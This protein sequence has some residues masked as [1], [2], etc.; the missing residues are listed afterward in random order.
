MNVYVPAAVGIPETAP[1]AAFHVNPGGSAPLAIDVVN[2]G[3]PPAEAIM[4]LYADPTTPAGGAPDRVGSGFTVI[5]TVSS[6]FVPGIVAVK[7]TCIGEV[8]P[9]GAVYVVFAV[10]A[11]LTVP[12]PAPLH[13]I[14]DIVHATL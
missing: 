6:L 10:V 3:V 11:E 2:V 7:I 14:P 12:H 4:V 9:A 8:T 5:V 13:E 1:V